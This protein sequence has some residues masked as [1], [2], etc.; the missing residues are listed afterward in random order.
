MRTC[1]GRLDCT[2]EEGIANTP[3]VI[4]RVEI[5]MALHGENVP[6]V[7][8]FSIEKLSSSTIEELIHPLI[9][10]ALIGAR[11]KAENPRP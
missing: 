11:M 7:E 9:A 6:P 2:G 1:R 10:F 8:P 5:L 4:E 3:E